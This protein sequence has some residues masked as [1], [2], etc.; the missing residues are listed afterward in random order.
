MDDEQLHRG[1]VSEPR[2]GEAVSGARL[3]IVALVAAICWRRHRTRALRIAAHR[4]HACR[5]GAGRAGAGRGARAAAPIDLTGYWVAFV[6]EDWRYRMV[7]PREG[8]LPRRADHE[9]SARRS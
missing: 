5:R 6:T 9:G 8:R 2:A 7:T 3:S 4:R 1:R